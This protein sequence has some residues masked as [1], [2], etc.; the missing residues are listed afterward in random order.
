MKKI[1]LVA[2]AVS[3]A[4]I[5]AA[6]SQTIGVGHGRFKSITDTFG[7]DPDARTGS[8]GLLIVE[9]RILQNKHY[10]FGD[11]IIDCR[12]NQHALDIKSKRDLDGNL[13][14]RIT[15]RQEFWPTPAG[16]SIDRV[17]RTLCP[18]K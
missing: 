5:W 3:A 1:L 10:Y 6:Q 11:A 9:I 8:T 17:S 16:G 4:C 2:A 14:E 15:S 7:Y 12:R 18:K 13:V